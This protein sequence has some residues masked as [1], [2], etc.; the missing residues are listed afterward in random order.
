MILQEL[1]IKDLE[2]VC[3]KTRE[4]IAFGNRVLE[5][6]EP[7]LYFE[8][9]QIALLSEQVNPI[10]AR[11]GWGNEPLV[12]WEDRKETMFSFTN[13]TLNTTSFN[14]L[15]NA[16]M[17]QAEPEEPLFFVEFMITIIYKND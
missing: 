6:G 13:G 1:G 10:M 12:I 7:V 4:E 15:L 9:I 16:D 5:A 14:L 3:L 8:N 11:G 17:L 2:R